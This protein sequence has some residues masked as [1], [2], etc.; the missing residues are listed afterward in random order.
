MSKAFTKESDH[1]ASERLPDRAVP[2]D[3]NLVTAAGLAMIGEE[4]AK[5]REEQA[6]TAADDGDAL[7]RISRELRYWTS[8]QATAQLTELTAGNTVQFGS[9]VTFSRSDGRTQTFKIVG[10]DE[11]NPAHGTLSYISPAAKALLG[12]AVGDEVQ[13]GATHAEIIDLK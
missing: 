1:G 11:A 4:I 6:A 8:R 5:L 7:A 10:V 3:A 13:I 12:R 2:P 9:T